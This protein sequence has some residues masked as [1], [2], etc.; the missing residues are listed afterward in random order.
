[1]ARPIK[2]EL[3]Q[4]EL[5]HLTDALDTLSSLADGINDDGTLRKQIKALDKMLLRHGWKRKYN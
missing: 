2:L 3:T 5:L 1:M 4:S